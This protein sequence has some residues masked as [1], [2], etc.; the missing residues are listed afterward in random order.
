M[1]SSEYLLKGQNL[2]KELASEAAAVAS[3]RQ[4]KTREAIPKEKTP[5][6]QKNSIEKKTAIRESVNRSSDI[7]DDEYYNSVLTESHMWP[8]TS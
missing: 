3:S 6:R 7:L 8:V 4:E 2:M 5:S 1:A